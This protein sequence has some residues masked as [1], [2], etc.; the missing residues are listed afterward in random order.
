[1]KEK[2]ERLNQELEELGRKMKTAGMFEKPAIAEQMLQRQLEL[3]ALLIKGGVW[4][5]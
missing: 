4:Q 5:P 2:A 1:M 3:N